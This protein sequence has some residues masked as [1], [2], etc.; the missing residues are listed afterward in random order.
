MESRISRP[1]RDRLVAILLAALAL[2]ACDRF[3]GIQG[4]VTDC[5]TAAGLAG[6]GVD[7]HVDRGYRDRMQ[8]L[9]DYVATDDEGHYAVHLNEPERTWATLT[10]HLDG[11]QS[12]TSPQF[13]GHEY[14]DPPYDPCLTPAPAP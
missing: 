9:P 4:T 13:Q 14:V 6:V 3:F 5:D 7:V 11:Y 8:S 12:L 1:R 2:P 10:F